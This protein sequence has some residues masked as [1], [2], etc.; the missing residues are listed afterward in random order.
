MEV[1]SCSDFKVRGV[2]DGMVRAVVKVA[3]EALDTLEQWCIWKIIIDR[4]T[5]DSIHEIR[6][7]ILHHM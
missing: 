5:V 2:H 4:D 7:V 3:D 1:M 6:E